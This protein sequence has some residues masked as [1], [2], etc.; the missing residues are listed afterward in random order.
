MALSS[1]SRAQEEK[2][3]Q[4]AQESQTSPAENAENN[5]SRFFLGGVYGTVT[6]D[7]KTYQQLGLKPEFR[8]GKFGMCLDMYLLLDENGNVRKEDWDEFKDYMDR[9]YYVSY[10]KKGDPFHFKFGGIDSTTLGYG[11]IISGYCNTLEYPTYKRQGLEISADT[12]HAGFELIAGNVKDLTGK[13]PAIMGGGR[14]YVKPLSRIQIG[15][16]AAGDTNEYKGLRDS[17]DDG[18]P[19]RIDRYPNDSRY[20]T[21]EEYYLAKTHNSAL[22]DQMI[23]YGA[24]SGTHRS[25]LMDIGK[26]KSRTGFVSADA[27]I[28]LIKYDPLRFDIYAQ[29]TESL[30]T[31]GRGYT[32]PGARFTAGDVLEISG[33]YIRQTD[34]FI[35]GYYNDTYDLE[36]AVFVKDA[37]VN[38]NCITKK[39][40]LESAKA[41]NGYTGSVTLSIMNLFSVTGRYQEMR[42]GDERDKSMRAELNIRKDL[43]PMIT[44]AKA[45]YVQNN[46]EKFA[47]KTPSSVLGATLGLGI[48]KGMSLDFNYL[49]TFEDKNG[50][51]KIKGA[52]ETNK[53]ISVSTSAAL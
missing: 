28:T 52:D 13:N 22:V 49:M 21:E 8:F 27:G 36:R 33:G 2:E 51:G 16:S 50:D 6:V 44:K 29:A 42:K 43:I 34:N 47:F 41:A 31:K 5:G 19:D 46:V 40:K 9:I 10:A 25:Q 24:I 1:P 17:D 11:S 39:E 4:P 15:F 37:D 7:G 3:N 14:L 12:E 32:L 48:A 20:A 26:R 23:Q 30:N 38:F 53:R 35:F 45:Y 18:I